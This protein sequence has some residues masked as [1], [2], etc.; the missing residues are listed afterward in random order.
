MGIKTFTKSSTKIV[1]QQAAVEHV[2]KLTRLSSIKNKY[3]LEAVLCCLSKCVKI[4]PLP[5][6]G[7]VIILLLLNALYFLP[8]YQAWFCYHY[9]LFRL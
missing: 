7:R 6:V 2:G 1:L 9:K 3:N 4:R 8:L 5:I